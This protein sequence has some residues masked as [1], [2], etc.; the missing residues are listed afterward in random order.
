MRDLFNP[1]EIIDR[2]VFMLSATVADLSMIEATFKD[3]LHGDGP[4]A[5]NFYATSCRD[6]QR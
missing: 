1:E 5:H 6:I 2:W 4:P 3:A